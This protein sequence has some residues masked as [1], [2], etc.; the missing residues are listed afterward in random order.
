M[1]YKKYEE[2]KKYQSV[3]KCTWLEAKA[4]VRK[5]AKAVKKADNKESK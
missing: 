1:D 3:N 5:P 4:A 2:A